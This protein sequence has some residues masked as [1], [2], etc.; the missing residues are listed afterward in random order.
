MSD[1]PTQTTSSPPT[2]N[3]PPGSR[4]AWYI[5]ALGLGIIAAGIIGFLIGGSNESNNAQETLKAITRSVGNTNSTATAVVEAFTPTPSNTPP[6]T[7]T[8]TPEIPQARILP[9]SAV[10]RLGPSEAYPIVATLLQDY[11]V[12]IIGYSQDGNWLQISYMLDEE[13]QTGFVRPDL[14]EV[15][16]GSLTGV[17]IA[18]N[19]PTL[20][21][22]PTTIPPTRTPTYTPSPTPT[23]TVTVTSSPAIPQARILPVSAV[24]R[25]GPGAEYPVIA[26]LSQD[27]RVE[28]T[29]YSEDGNWLEI[30]FRQDGGQR[31]TGFVSPELVQVTGGSMTGVAV[32]QNY[33]TLTA[34]FS[35]ENP[36]ARVLPIIASVRLGP[37]VEYPVLNLVRQ[38]TSVEILSTS[39][40]G[41]WFQVAY[42]DVEGNEVEGFVEGTYL[43]VT[44]G[45]LTGVAVAIAPTLS[46]TPTATF[47]PLIPTL[48]PS[49]TATAG[50]PVAYA[51][52]YLGV[53]RE[54]PAEAFSAVGAVDSSTPLVVT[55]ISPDGLWLQVRYEGS[56]TGLGWISLQ[57]VQ[58][59]GAI[60][61]LPV[62]QG[63]VLPTPV[64]ATGGTGGGGDTSGSGA[65]PVPSSGTGNASGGGSSAGSSGPITPSPLPNRFVVDYENLP[66]VNAFAYGYNIAIIGIGDGSR[67]ESTMTFYYAKSASP[68]QNRLTMNLTGA[69]IDIVA[70]EDDISA[71]T[72]LLPIT[73]GVYE[74]QNYIYSGLL[75]LCIDAGAELGVEDLANELV[76]TIGGDFN[77]IDD[78]QQD[79]VFGIVDTNGI[80][81]I[82]AVHYQLIGV[83]TPDNYEATD[84]VKAD[85][86]WTP[87]ET[88]LLGYRITFA[89][90]DNQFI[91]R[92]LIEDIDPEIA[93]FESFEGVYTLELIPTGINDVAVQTS[94]PPDA[95]NIMLGVQ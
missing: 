83:G 84:L 56:P 27:S 69:F 92:D 73:L 85:F 17:A 59:V 38:D 65:T 51:V 43:Q 57:T 58:I 81:G 68:A 13:P 39:E 34:T 79:A 41:L 25:L 6:A 53:V 15:T 11:P 1:V 20:T 87:D 31:L 50:P 95:C 80:A 55:A 4:Q 52:G 76:G 72:D 90:G 9:V 62:V 35:P 93:N 86:W 71:L 12:E 7:S 14:I 29:G 94:M 89:I 91:G 19:Y 44:G 40:D 64:A 18:Q 70:G 48:I 67:Y 3:G 23:S 37:S 61:A 66:D 88:Q 49:P 42:E 36:Q 2:P 54:G 8:A 33:P 82:P 46:P 78:V 28:I 16:G 5:A 75:D 24:V 60:S 10:V 30:S 74:G 21:F 26:T 63:P 45:T 77:P 47:T 22:T 32:A